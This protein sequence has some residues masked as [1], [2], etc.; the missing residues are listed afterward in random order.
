MPKKM[1]DDMI[2]IYKYDDFF[3]AVLNCAVRYALGRQSYMPGL[4][5][6][7][8]TPMLPKLSDKTLWCFE[9]DVSDA[10]KYGNLGDM[11]IDAPKWYK[12]L[13]DVRAENER[14][15]QDEKS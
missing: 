13:N 8:I 5:V 15:K 6:D 12:F 11:S 14:R 4:V 10:V 1:P 2:I 7:Y 3:G 9:K